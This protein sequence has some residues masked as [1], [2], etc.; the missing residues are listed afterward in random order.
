MRH[1]A[2]LAHK[3]QTL[4]QP[5]CRINGQG[6]ERFRLVARIT[7]HHA[8]VACADLVEFVAFDHF[9]MLGFVGFIHA[10]SDIGTLVM[11]GIQHAAG[12]A[13]ETVL[14]TLV[15]DVLQHVARDSLHVNVSLRANFA[16][17]DD[18]ARG[19]Q[20]L[21]RAAHLCRIC[22]RAVRSNVAGLCQLRFL[23]Q[24]CV[25]NGVGN[26]VADL[27]GV[28]FGHGLRREQERGFLSLSHE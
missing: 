1:D 7:E 28:T 5:M 25:Q 20:G 6:H 3:G 10:H 14:R 24:K 4:R 11:N 2:L 9:A 22:R 19:S 17:H 23:L 12:F 13:V 18:H 26:L 15:A 8:L 16:G 21:A 27:V